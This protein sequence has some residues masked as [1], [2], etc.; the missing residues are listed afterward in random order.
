MQQTHW[1]VTLS[2]FQAVT[3]PPVALYP[4]I[5]LQIPYVD[6]SGSFDDSSDGPSLGSPASPEFNCEGTVEDN[7]LMTL[8]LEQ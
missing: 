3:H 2:L 1:E 8:L 6:L 5:H 4:V 7:T